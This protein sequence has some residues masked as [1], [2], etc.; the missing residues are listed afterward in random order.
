MHEN[1]QHNNTSFAI[2]GAVNVAVV[3]DVVV[4]VAKYVLLAAVDG[5]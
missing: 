1:K 4:V 3:V 5:L 2:V